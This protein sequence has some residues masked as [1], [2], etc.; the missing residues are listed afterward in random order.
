[1]SSIGSILSTEGGGF[2]SEPYLVIMMYQKHFLVPVGIILKKKMYV[3]FFQNL[4]WNQA[5][6][7]KFEMLL[8]FSNMEMLMCF[9]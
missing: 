5:V 2:F 1:M 9:R 3:K 7:N 8:L 4:N 6:C